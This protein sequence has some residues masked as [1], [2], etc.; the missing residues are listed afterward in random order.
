MQ[1]VYKIG[2]KNVDFQKI[3]H[4]VEVELRLLGPN[5]DKKVFLKRNGG[6]LYQQLFE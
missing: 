2:S 5:M 6:I 3:Q 4:S 1:I